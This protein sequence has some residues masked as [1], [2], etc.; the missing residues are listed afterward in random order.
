MSEKTAFPP[1]HNPSINSCSVAGR[2]VGLGAGGFGCAGDVVS[3]FTWSSAPAGEEKGLGKKESVSA[4]KMQ[5]STAKNSNNKLFL[6]EASKHAP[7]A[8]QFQDP[9]QL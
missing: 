7:N 4:N 5:L 1:R 8:N 6:D 2:G 9:K 3:S